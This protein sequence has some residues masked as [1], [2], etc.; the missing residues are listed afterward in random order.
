VK[1]NV[2]Y[3]KIKSRIEGTRIGIEI[4]SGFNWA[5]Y[6]ASQP[7][8]LFFGLYSDISGGQMPNRVP[9]ATDYLTVA[10]AAGSETYQ[11]PNTAPYLSAD[12]DQIWHYTNDSIRVVLSSELISYDFSRT[13]IK[14]DNT[15]P[16]TLRWI[17]ILSSDFETARE[18]KMRDSFDL[19]I[20]WSGVLSFHGNVKGNK[21]LFQ[22]YVWTPE[23][24][25]EAET[26]TLIA[27]YTT[28]A[29]EPLTIALD[30][31]IKGLKAGGSPS[32]WSRIDCL[33]KYN[34]LA[35]DQIVFN[36]KCNG[37]WDATLVG[38]PTF[39]P[40]LYIETAATGTKYVDTNF[41]P[42]N[43]VNFQQNDAS[44][45]DG[46]VAFTTSSYNGCFTTGKGLVFRGGNADGRG[47]FNSATVND[48]LLNIQIGY[49]IQTR[50]GA[51][52]A[53][54][55]NGGWNA[56]NVASAARPDHTSLVGAWHN[57]AVV[58]GLTTTRNK[59]QLFGAYFSNA[60]ADAIRTLL[61]TFDIT[62]AAL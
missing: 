12:T 26:L 35:I 7:E 31:L 24:I 33:Q 56:N 43:G 42:A 23:G 11:C 27:K 28:P 15:A 19:S 20:W 61:E 3:N 2:L 1:V 45:F 37:F 39:A 32:Y 4:Q 14:Y 46:I 60:E 36:F 16:Y 18:N 17:M 55:Y 57:N 47:F 5:A 29:T 62:V 21:P 10:G 30:T 54:I 58:S 48:P 41:I 49:N 34:L 8:V 9:G 50:N 25:Y 38:S 13:I 51:N 53:T 40:K 44:W 59:T 6:W 52:T 22:Q